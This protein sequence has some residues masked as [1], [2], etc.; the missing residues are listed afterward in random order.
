MILSNIAPLQYHTTVASKRIKICMTC[1][2]DLVQTVVIRLKE[3][4]CT[5]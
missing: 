4:Q 2:T 1:K 3:E 5:L